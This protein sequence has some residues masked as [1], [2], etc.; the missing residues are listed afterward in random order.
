ME[1]PTTARLENR[2]TNNSEEAWHLHDIFR[3][4]CMQGFCAPIDWVMWSQAGYRKTSEGA[5]RASPKPGHLQKLFTSS[6]WQWRYQ[7]SLRSVRRGRHDTCSPDK[8]EGTSAAVGQRGNPVTSPY[9][10]VRFPVDV[11]LPLMPADHRHAEDDR[12]P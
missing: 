2:S 9:F 1:K 8:G 12:K 10:A 11:S 5:G 4:V 6:Q 7:G 3:F